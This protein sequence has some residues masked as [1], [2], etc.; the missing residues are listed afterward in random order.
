[1]PSFDHN[2][3]SIAY[4]LRGE[5]TDLVFMHGLGADREQSL[6]ALSGLS[7][8]RLICPDMPG[9]GDSLPAPSPDGQVSFGFR[10]FADVAIAL[11]DH[12]EIESALLGG[13]SMGSG[14]SLNVALR[15]P[16]RVKGLVLV[17]PAWL[18]QSRPDNLHVIDAL[19][20]WIVDEGL[21][22]AE[23]RLAEHSVYSDVLSKNPKCAASISSVLTRPQALESASV[24]SALVQDAPFERMQDL[25]HIGVPALVIGCVGDPLHPA[26]VAETLTDYFPQGQYQQIPPRYLEPQ[27]HHKVL[28]LTIHA[29]LNKYGLLTEG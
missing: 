19:G 6:S 21:V 11:L 27:E 17:R 1:M 12:L 4:D 5:G 7:G 22:E 2:G 3:Q 13:I 15:R 25:A 28:T 10:H 29:F 8:I 23:A 18:D 24:L 20:Q 9:H 16:E 26:S 14:I